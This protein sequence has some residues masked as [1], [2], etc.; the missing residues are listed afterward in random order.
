MN[1]KS[2]AAIAYNS[3]LQTFKVAKKKKW[4]RITAAQSAV[5]ALNCLQKHPKAYSSSGPI[6]C[7]LKN[8]SLSI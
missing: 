5:N 3:G 4:V 1:E 8:V 6:S 7:E 2:L